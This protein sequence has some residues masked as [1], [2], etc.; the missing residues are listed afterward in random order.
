MQS[1]RQKREFRDACERARA[2]GKRVGLVPTM[3][4]L[5]EGHLAL[6]DGCR[7][8]GATFVAVSIFVNPTQFGPN[9]DLARY[10]RTL[11]QDLAKCRD[12]GVDL[13]FAP[14]EEEIYPKD[15]RTSVVVRG[16]TEHLEGSHRPGHFDG[17]A[18][19]VAKLLQLTGP[20]LA[21]FGQKDYQQWLILQ[22]MVRDLELPIEMRAH[23]IVR[24]PDGLA[25]SSR[26]R[27]LTREQ[28]NKALSLWTGLTRA[29]EL[30]QRGTRDPAALVEAA[31]KPIEAKADRIDY[32]EA[33][34]AQTLEPARSPDQSELAILI[35][36]HFGGTRLI[37][38]IL[39]GSSL[40]LPE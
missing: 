40:L 9:E 8:H 30:H 5:H 29:K 21:V 1:V 37:D 13:V 15:F 24:E 19:V 10:P 26:N 3:G 27:Y 20:S 31:R 39:L 32:V 33:V 22:A 23:P 28:R 18:T 38:N 35:A 17:V 16:L 12:R 36:A 4:A 14:S 11:E 25:L 6:I 2:G 7:D 34:D